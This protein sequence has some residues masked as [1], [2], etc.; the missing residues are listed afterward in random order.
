ME[1]E[2]MNSI[3]TVEEVAV[4]LRTNR[5]TIYRLIAKSQL[6]AFKVG[7]ELRITKIAVTNFI[8]EQEATYGSKHTNIVVP[9]LRTL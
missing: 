9:V 6:I 1:L 3:L 7:S 5:N 4:F 8:H 2:K